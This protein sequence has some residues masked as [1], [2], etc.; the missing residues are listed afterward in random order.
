MVTQLHNFKNIF[1][2]SSP[3]FQAVSLDCQIVKR[4]TRAL[5]PLL[6]WHRYLFA[7][8]RESPSNLVPG[9]F[10]GG[11][12]R[13]E[14]EG[15]RRSHSLPM[16]AKPVGVRAWPAPFSLTESCPGGFVLRALCWC[17][18]LLNASPCSAAAC[19]PPPLLAPSSAASLRICPNL[20]LGVLGVW[21]DLSRET[22][23]PGNPIEGAP[24]TL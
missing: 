13:R 22:L 15:E 19:K 8:L 12:L 20:L 10:G 21:Q 4:L 5:F 18:L 1:I 16:E 9:P 2:T 3:D 14:R 6:Q 17:P 11:G 24:R 7:L 23:S